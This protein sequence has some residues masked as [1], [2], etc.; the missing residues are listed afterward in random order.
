ML[1]KRNQLAIS[2]MYVIHSLYKNT[3]I[4][5]RGAKILVT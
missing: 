2:V 3:V 1:K 4:L 5:G